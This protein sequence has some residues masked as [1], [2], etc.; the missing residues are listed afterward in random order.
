MGL[1]YATPVDIWSVGCIMAELY[2]K[3][4]IFAGQYEMDQLN[5]IFDILGTPSEEAWPE[6]AA[7]VRANFR[8]TP[9]KD[10]AEV[11]PGIDSNA[12]ELLEVR[13]LSE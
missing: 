5:K 6:N 8:V 1:S 12:K 13:E 7:V 10:L 3:K 11:I 2:L 9:P 4:A